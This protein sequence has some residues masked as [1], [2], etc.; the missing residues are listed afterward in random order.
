M[1]EIMETSMTEAGDNA[2]K[3]AI[4]AEKSKYEN[5][6]K[7]VNFEKIMQAKK[8]FR[9]KHIEKLN[10]FTLDFANQLK[11]DDKKGQDVTFD[12]LRD[13][14]YKIEEDAVK[15]TYK[16]TF[17]YLYDEVIAKMD[18]ELNKKLESDPDNAEN[19]SVNA[20]KEVKNLIV[21]FNYDVIKKDA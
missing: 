6:A 14:S 4:E 20:Q 12:D 10:K 15:L 13:F 8:E 9:E 1:S 5:L 17:N 18:E 16:E 21:D 2:M 11:A 19:W 3:I 7:I